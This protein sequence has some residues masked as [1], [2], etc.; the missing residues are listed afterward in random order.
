MRDEELDRLGEKPIVLKTG[1]TPK[2]FSKKYSL[3]SLSLMLK[4]ITRKK[5]RTNNTINKGEVI[6]KNM[7]SLVDEIFDVMQRNG[8]ISS[9]F[10]PRC[11]HIEK[12]QL[13]RKYV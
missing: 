8:I 1:K 4:V 10:T 2:N 12:L 11:S 5:E 13:I 3:G 7:D 9:H 6:Q